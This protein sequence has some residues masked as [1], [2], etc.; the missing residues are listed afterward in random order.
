MILYNS[1][2]MSTE[3]KKVWRDVTEKTIFEEVVAT[4]G[5]KPELVH[6]YVSIKESIRRILREISRGGKNVRMLRKLQAAAAPLKIVF[7]TTLE[8]PSQE[9]DWVAE[10]M[11]A[12]GFDT[13]EK[14]Q[15]YIN[16][17]KVRDS[18]F[19]SVKTISLTVNGDLVT[20]MSPAIDAVNKDKQ[21]SGSDRTAGFIVAGAIGGAGILLL[22]IFV[23]KYY[24]SRNDRDETNAI[25]VVTFDKNIESYEESNTNEP[26]GPYGASS[27][28]ESLGP[29]LG[30][31]EAKAGDDI[32]ALE[33]P[34]IFNV[35]YVEGDKTV[36]E[37]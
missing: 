12:A 24:V 37:R 33:D 16:S 22:G 29:C 28:N 2:E 4:T 27:A 34:T 32:S 13:Q 18:H 30:V 11:V 25:S 3:S 36:G 5:I 8:F 19:D 1:E 10:E 7:I 23:G 14:Q 26:R 9:E 15:K 31:I 20:D 17:L 21:K 35:P 6:V